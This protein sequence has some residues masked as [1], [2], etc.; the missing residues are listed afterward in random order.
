MSPFDLEWSHL[1]YPFVLTP[2]TS[3]EYILDKAAE[4]GVSRRKVLETFVDSFRPHVD[5]ICFSM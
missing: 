3:E 5:S 4:L 2:L 1:L